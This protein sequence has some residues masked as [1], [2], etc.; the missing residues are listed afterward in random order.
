[1]KFGNVIRTSIPSDTMK[2]DG[3]TF[4]TIVIDGGDFL[5]ELTNLSIN[6]GYFDESA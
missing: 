2:I 3:G 6:G 4:I 1:M 5:S